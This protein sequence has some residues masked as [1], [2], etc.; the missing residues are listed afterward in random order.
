MCQKG[1]V[2]FLDDVEYINIAMD[3]LYRDI[4]GKIFF[5]NWNGE[6]EDFWEEIELRQGQYLIIKDDTMYV[7]DNLDM[8]KKEEIK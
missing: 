1:K 4:T 6:E 5:D 7:H 2:N 3:E 8:F